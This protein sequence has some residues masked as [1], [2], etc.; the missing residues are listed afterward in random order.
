MLIRLAYVTSPYFQPLSLGCHDDGK[1]TSMTEQDCRGLIG[2]AG[3]WS[4]S[5]TM[6]ESG[7]GSAF[8]RSTMS[9]RPSPPEA[10]MAMT[11]GRSVVVMR[12]IRSPSTA[13]IEGDS[14]R[15]SIAFL[16]DHP[17][18]AVPPPKG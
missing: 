4:T 3:R 16:G 2:A 7:F 1:A 18:L 14:V 15:A 9:W 6:A 17:T 13:C 8:R 5:M 10:P 11:Y 12:Q